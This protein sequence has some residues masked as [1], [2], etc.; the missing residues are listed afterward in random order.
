MKVVSF[1]FILIAFARSQLTLERKNL[2]TLS[3]FASIHFNP[4]EDHFNGSILT[5]AEALFLSQPLPIF[6]HVDWVIWK[7]TATRP[8]LDPRT[9]LCKSDLLVQ[10]F[11]L[12]STLPPREYNRTLIIAG[13]NLSLSDHESTINKLLEMNIV[14]N[15]LH[16]RKDK[17][18]PHVFLLPKGF[19][20]L[21]LINSGLSQYSS[22]MKSAQSRLN[23][24]G[25]K[26]ITVLKYDDRFGCRVVA[27]L[28]PATHA[29]NND[30]IVTIVWRRGAYW[31]S[32]LSCSY[33]WLD[34]DDSTFLDEF[35]FDCWSMRVIPVLPH[36]SLHTDLRSL[37]YPLFSHHN[38]RGIT[39]EELKAEYLLRGR[40]VDWRKVWGLLRLDSVVHIGG[41][42]DE[43]RRKAAA[44][45]LSLDFL[46]KRLKSH[47]VHIYCLSLQG[48]SARKQH[49]K[50]LFAS[51]H[52]HDIHTF[53]DAIPVHSFD[54][55]VLKSNGTIA[56]SW[57]TNFGF[58]RG[59]SKARVACQLSHMS[60]LSQF[61][62]SS[63]ELALVMEDDVV[64]SDWLSIEEVAASM[65]TVLEITY[66]QWDAIYM[67]FCWEP[68]I[69]D[70]AFV[71]QVWR[72]VSTHEPFMTVEYTRAIKPLCR[73]AVLYTRRLARLVLDT[74]APMVSSGDVQLANLMCQQNLTFLRTD[75]PIFLQAND[76]FASTIGNQYLKLVHLTRNAPPVCKDKAK[77]DID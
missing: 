34:R 44:P 11:S 74:W 52:L 48:E 8:V 77:F 66:P 33:S 67:G 46:P 68:L 70:H 57:T 72:Q 61:L 36:N 25:R 3:E 13:A 64:I 73:H 32:L 62:S 9:I 58:K 10:K 56:R 17:P 47:G 76:D 75:R 41:V 69:T 59:Y 18:H 35:L 23:A 22:A 65:S 53:V 71:S 6:S 1:L 16:E 21:S 7:M 27:P 19:N 40:Y 2:Q 14:S 31:K 20:F 63:H 51:L 49:M 54:D 29:T 37:G 39:N 50:T 38:I 24:H 28:T 30:E 45:K 15:V 12:L 42:L 60:A 26:P 43:R 55:K 4:R 5:S